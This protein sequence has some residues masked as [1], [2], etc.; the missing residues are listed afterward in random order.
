MSEILVKS[1][2][3]LIVSEVEEG[4]PAAR[5][6]VRV[7][8]LLQQINGRPLL[9]ILDYR[10]HAADARL[11]LTLERD[12]Q[13]LAVLVRKS[14]DEDAGLA[15]ESDLGD[16]IHTC[17]NKCVFCFIHQMPKK[18][19][20]SLYLMDDDFRLSF[21]HG[22]Y[23]TLTNLS[24]EEWARIK[25]QKLSPLYVSVHATDPELRR[26]LLGRKE[27]TPILPQLRELADERIDVHAQ[28]VLCPGL[29]DGDA[30]DR[31]LDAL[32]AE[33]R[34]QTNK[35]AGVQSVAIVPVGLTRFRE[36]LPQ[37]AHVERDYARRMIAH[38]KKREKE[39]QARL[40]TR[41]A[42]LADEWYFL[43]E[44]PVPGKSHYE[45]FPQLEDGIGTVRLFL[46]NAKQV[47]RRLPECASVP[48][49]AT[50]V[51]AEMPASVVRAFAA[52]LNQ[53]AGVD[54]NVCVV[55]NEFFGGDIHIAGLLTAADILAQLQTFPDC[56]PTV[57]L[58]KI[59]LRDETLFLDDRTLEDARRE[60][61]L[62]LRAVGNTPRDLAEALGLLLPAR[63]VRPPES[64]WFMEE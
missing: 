13:P 8:D 7:G 18:M 16:R 61:G 41:F 21:M 12:G 10:F 22:N 43:A 42:W 1:V 28:I 15:F 32:A 49:A 55:R 40:G 37:L 48:V 50:L 24:D 4:S 62:D 45:E 5:A 25:E 20:R 47:S 23:V 38:I 27:P 53:I 35:R 51:T 57:Y 26:V 59:C 14:E 56:K 58:P 36:R 3:A 39:F 6:G 11:R 31:T 34:A 63:T 60:S 30:L 44:Q 17:K 2:N 54:I 33:H 46:E 64:H 52:R 9:D 19:R 29:N